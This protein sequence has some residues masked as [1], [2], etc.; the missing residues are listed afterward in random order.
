MKPY[1][2]YAEILVAIFFEQIQS[3][4][5]RFVL[6]KGHAACAL[7]K[8]LALS[9]SMDPELLKIFYQDGTL[10]AAHPTCQGSH[11]K[12]HAISFGTASLGYGPSLSLGMAL[13]ARLKNQ[14]N[15]RFF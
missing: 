8:A 11:V 1:L 12:I 9:G 15:T 2:S 5:D 13:T 14:N 3:D 10:L 6:S 7:Y 4:S